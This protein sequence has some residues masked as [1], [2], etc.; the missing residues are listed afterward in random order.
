MRISLLNPTLGATYTNPA[1]I[2]ILVV[3]TIAL[4]ALMVSVAKS[5]WSSSKL[6]VSAVSIFYLTASLVFSSML[7]GQS[8]F[9]AANRVQ[10]AQ[11]FLLW[12]VMSVIIL[13]VVGSF[14]SRVSTANIIIIQQAIVLVTCVIPLVSFKFVS[15]LLVLEVVNFFVISY[16]TFIANGVLAGVIQFVW[17]SLAFNLSVIFSWVVLLADTYITCGGYYHST[18]SEISSLLLFL[19]VGVKVGLYPVGFWIIDFYLSLDLLNLTGYFIAAY[20]PTLMLCVA[21]LL[22]CRVCLHLP[23]TTVLYAYV[24]I[25][26][27]STWLEFERFP[28]FQTVDDN[29][30]IILAMLT[31]FLATSTM[32]LIV[33]CLG[34]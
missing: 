24:I 32:L 6:I 15:I 12:V 20:I 29:L 16:L 19:A 8:I 26:L 5:N 10:I 21:L 11:L 23:N 2:A 31:L 27:T 4:L 3:I 1:G 9:F 28:Y 22:S 7:S 13:R 33:G 25:A 30:S 17:V 18:S 14:F 34:L